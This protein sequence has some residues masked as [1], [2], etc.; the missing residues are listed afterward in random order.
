MMRLFRVLRIEFLIL[1]T[2]LAA[3]GLIGWAKTLA[4]ADDKP[5]YEIILADDLEPFRSAFNAD[6]DH[7]R[8]VLLIGPT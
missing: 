3:G 6:A 8:A 7:I 5:D 1:T 4:S 2:V